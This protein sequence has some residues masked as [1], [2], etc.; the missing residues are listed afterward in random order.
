M[1]AA[2]MRSSYVTNPAKAT[3][4]VATRATIAGLAQPSV[5]PRIRANISAVSATMIRAVPTQLAPPPAGLRDSRSRATPTANAATPIGRLTKKMDRQPRV[6]VS[7]PP[8]SGPMALAPPS[9]APKTPRA[10]AKGS[11]GELG[12][13]QRRG[14]GEQH[15]ATHS[16]QGAEQ[17]ERH[18]GR[19][20]GTRQRPGGEDDQ[21]D[22]EQP[23]SA[24]PVAQGGRRQQQHRQHV[25]IGGAHPLQ[26]RQ[27]RP[28]I[29]LNRWQRHAHDGDI[30]QQH[31][32]RRAHQHQSPPLPRRHARD[33]SHRSHHPR[34]RPLS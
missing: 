33:V 34:R 15:R 26:V 1:G 21:A 22:Q 19:G 31:E 17:L 32:R 2:A 14:D 28:Q 27:A 11:A 7:T 23:A 8:A 12:A 3:A 16:L 18:R 30:Q 24:H 6:S 9:V 10:R 29:P 20:Q 13:Q 4:A 5:S 25:G